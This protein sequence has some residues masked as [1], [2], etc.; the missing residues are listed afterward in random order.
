MTFALTQLRPSK[1]AAAASTLKW[2]MRRMK[3]LKWLKKEKEKEKELGNGFVVNE[4]PKKSAKSLRSKVF[5]TWKP[6]AALG[7]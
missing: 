6:S 1:S 4:P 7:K 5:L 3:W 2:P